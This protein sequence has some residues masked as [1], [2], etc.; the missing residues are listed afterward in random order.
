[1]ARGPSI[2]TARWP[3]AGS[4][5]RMPAWNASS[6]ATSAKTA[7]AAGVASFLPASGRSAMRHRLA[8]AIVLMLGGVAAA[9]AQQ[10]GSIGGARGITLGR[11][12]PGV[13]VRT[14][15]ASHGTADAW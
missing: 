7:T 5:W 4:R 14:D 13:A 15:G 1:M 8:L 3:A 10:T 6:R 9:Q 12:K 2:R 11:W